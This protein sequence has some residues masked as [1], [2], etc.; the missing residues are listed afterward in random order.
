MLN[1]ALGDI[2]VFFKAGR[3]RFGTGVPSL[4]AVGPRLCRVII[5]SSPACRDI[6]A[7]TGT[8]W[9]GFDECGDQAHAQ[10]TIAV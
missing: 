10:V 8:S 5:S 1:A 2:E 6:R 4:V 9:Q 7:A 3:G